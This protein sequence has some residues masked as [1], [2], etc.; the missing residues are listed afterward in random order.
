MKKCAACGKSNKPIAKVCES[1]GAPLDEMK[2]DFD[3]DQGK[4]DAAAKPPAPQAPA[5]PKPPAPGA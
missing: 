1:C 3:A 4:L 2:I 5:A